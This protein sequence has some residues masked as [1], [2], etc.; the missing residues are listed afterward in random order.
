VSPKGK[1]ALQRLLALVVVVLLPGGSVVLLVAF[2]V[3]RV[4]RA[5]TM[6]LLNATRRRPRLPR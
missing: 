5:R 3:R 2:V 6:S 4:R 1:R